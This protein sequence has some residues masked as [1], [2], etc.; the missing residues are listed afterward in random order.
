M[1]ADEGKT[2]ERTLADLA[3][4]LSSWAKKHDAAVV[5]L[6]QVKSDVG[7]RGQSWY[8]RYQGEGW[9]KAVLGTRPG[10]SKADLA[11]CG[12]LGERAKDLSYIWRPGRW[13]RAFGYKEVKDDRL[14]IIKAKVSFGREGTIVLGFN[15]ELS[16]L[17]DL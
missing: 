16:K 5:V 3:W 2:L 8:A 12:A 9:Q 15:G 6:S 17:Y 11:W 13:A 1:N 14:H 7:E 4:G 10:P